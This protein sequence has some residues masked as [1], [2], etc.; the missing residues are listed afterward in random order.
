MSNYVQTKTANPGITDGAGW[1]LRHARRVFNI[2]LKAGYGFAWEAWNKT[3]QRF[4]SRTLPKDV[5]VPVWF[6][7]TGTVSGVRK[8]WGHVVVN[9]PGRGLLSTPLSGHGQKWY[10][11]IADVERALGAKYAG[12]SLDIN[13]EAVAKVAPLSSFTD[14]ELATRVIAGEFKNGAERKKRLGNRYDAV[15]AIVNKRLNSTG[16]NTSVRRYTVKKGDTL[17]KIAKQYGTNWRTLY[18]YNR[19]AIGSNPNRIYSGLVLVIP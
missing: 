11:T 19:A 14:E 4:T 15:Q 7:W 2:P 1:C 13:G 18:A 17:S 5:A 3:T 16:G 12:W 9:F 8:N 10:A 6:E